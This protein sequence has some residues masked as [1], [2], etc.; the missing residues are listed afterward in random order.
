MG[1]NP[2]EE[3]ELE[4][5][6]LDAKAHTERAIAG[7]KHIKTGLPFVQ[8]LNSVTMAEAKLKAWRAKFSEDVTD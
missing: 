5:M 7:L 1:L 6:L 2:K 8:V 4:A 3:Q